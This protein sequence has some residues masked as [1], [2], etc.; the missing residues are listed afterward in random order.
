MVHKREIRQQANRDTP[1][2]ARFAWWPGSFRSRYVTARILEQWLT[3]EP[4]RTQ[5]T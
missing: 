1:V 4:L 3:A 5:G 2:T